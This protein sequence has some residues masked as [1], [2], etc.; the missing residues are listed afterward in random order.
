MSRQCVFLSVYPCA[1]NDTGMCCERWLWC[2]ERVKGRNKGQTRCALYDSMHLS[3]GKIEKRIERR[4]KKTKPGHTNMTTQG[5]KCNKKGCHKISTAEAKK[6]QQHHN[7]NCHIQFNIYIYIYIYISSPNHSKKQN[8]GNKQALY[9]ST[10][11]RQNPA[12]TKH[13]KLV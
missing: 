6:K 10:C 7:K 12:K 2:S 11:H 3:N 1:K 8:Y 4:K 13:D 5:H 9:S